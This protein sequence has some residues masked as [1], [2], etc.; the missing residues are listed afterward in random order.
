MKEYK[1]LYRKMLDKNIIRLAYVKMRKGKTKRPEIKYIDEHY[2]QE[3][4]RMYQ[5]ILNTKPLGIW[6]PN[7]D[8]AYCPE[9]IIPFTVKE[10]GKIRTIYKPNIIDQWI[11]HIIVCIIGP[12]IEAHAYFLSCGSMPKK[13]GLYGKR[14][15]EKWIKNKRGIRYFAKIDI[16]HFFAS[17]EYKVLFGWLSYNIVDEWFIYII[18]LCYSQFKKGLILGF[19]L[20]QWL[21]NYFLERLDRY[22]CN[23]LKVS[24]YVRYVD[25]MVFFDNSKQRLAKNV[26]LVS[27]F[28][29]IGFHLKLKN[30]YQVCKFVYYDVGRP[31]DYMGYKFYRHKTILRKN[32]LYKSV[33]I[34]RKL[35]IRQLRG[36]KIYLKHVRSLLSYMGW[37]KH[38]NSYKC[39]MIH[40]KPY[41]NLGFYKSI[42]S[43]VDTRASCDPA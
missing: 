31:L 8:L 28:L 20:S 14:H 35:Y 40:I 23:T 25:D 27:F 33:K 10:H 4:D 13:G 26:K 15:I 41:C 7:P 18:R 22:I 5:M 3:A 1:Y 24:K 12:I 30:N 6:V 37:Y 42:I 34:A 16:R 2:E 32:I 43:R 21:A 29:Q 9:K 38:T 17:I 11:H 36:K 19:Y 39:Y